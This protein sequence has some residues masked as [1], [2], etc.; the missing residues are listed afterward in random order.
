M[1][2]KMKYLLLSAIVFAGISTPVVQAATIPTCVPNVTCLQFGD[3]NVFSLPIL[4][5]AA[6]AGAPGPG[7][8]WY[9]ASNNGTVN[10]YTVIGRNNGQDGAGNVGAID[11]AF[12]TPSNN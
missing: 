11:G 2:K 9:V 12:N 4:N 6:G 1:I 8:P 3:F 5:L 10:Q 7:D